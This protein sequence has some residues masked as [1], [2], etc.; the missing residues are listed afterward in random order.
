MH[1]GADH[2]TVYSHSYFLVGCLFLHLFCSRTIRAGSLKHA[3][4]SDLWYCDTL[5]PSK[6][7]L[8]KYTICEDAEEGE[9]EE[10]ERKRRAKESHYILSD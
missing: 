5:L 1:A 7:M 2:S 4:L 6:F 8:E 9:G 10:K 3:G